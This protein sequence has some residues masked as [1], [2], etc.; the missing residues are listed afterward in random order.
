MKSRMNVI[1]KV[2]QVITDFYNNNWGSVDGFKMDFVYWYKSLD[3]NKYYG[4][5]VTKGGTIWSIPQGTLSDYQ[6]W[7][8]TNF[9]YD[10]N[11]QP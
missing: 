1:K 6:K 4:I 9:K 2:P 11:Q 7:V 5:S 10:Q 8:E 3:G